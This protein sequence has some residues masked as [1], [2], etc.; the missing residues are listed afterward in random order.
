MAMEHKR[1]VT[2]Q[3]V[4]GFALIAVLVLALWALLPSPDSPDR[5]AYTLAWSALFSVPLFLGIHTTLFAR[6]DSEDLIH[7][8]AS[9]QQLTF[10][11]AY[12]SNTVEQTLVNVLSALTLGMVVPIACIKL[13]PI[14]GCIFIIGRL[15]YYFT[16]KSKPMNRFTG[17]AVGYYVAI[18][19]VM[20]SIYWVVI[21]NY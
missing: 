15:L 14:Q 10:N 11:R 7:G 18:L 3:I 12:L 20:T 21:G 2:V 8:H 5:I 19:S 6:F 17:F 16:Y 1:N 13:V 9:S 4:I